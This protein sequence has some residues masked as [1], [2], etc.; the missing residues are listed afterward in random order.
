MGKA[1]N[2]KKLMGE[3]LG[4]GVSANECTGLY[5][6]VSLTPEEVARFHD[7]YMNGNPFANF[8]NAE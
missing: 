1:K 2:T 4:A 3:L 5:Q 8:D 7:Q 6:K